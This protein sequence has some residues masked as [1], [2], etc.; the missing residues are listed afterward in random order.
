MHDVVEQ[1]WTNLNDLFI[2]IHLVD[3]YSIKSVPNVLYEYILVP[4]S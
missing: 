4:A 3:R 1:D 2:E